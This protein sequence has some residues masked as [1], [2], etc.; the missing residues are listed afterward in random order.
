MTLAELV[1]ETLVEKH[2]RLMR[3]KCKHEPGALVVSTFCSHEASFTDTFCADC[4][5]HWRKDR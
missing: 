4:G 3:E 1:N 2:R 5:Q